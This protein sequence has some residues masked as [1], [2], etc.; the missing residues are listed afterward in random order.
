MEHWPPPV[1]LAF[2]FH[3]SS[4]STQPG[5]GASFSGPPQVFVGA[6]PHGTETTA[7]AQE[8]DRG[9]G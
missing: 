8:P 2:P 1:C 9:L 4:L 3:G 5:T 6:A 7:G